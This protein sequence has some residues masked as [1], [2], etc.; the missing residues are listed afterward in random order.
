RSFDRL[1]NL[2]IAQARGRDDEAGGPADQVI[3][4]ASPTTESASRLTAVN[5]AASL[6]R[7]GHQVVLVEAGGS[8]SVDSSPRGVVT[9]GLAEVLAGKATVAQALRRAPYHPGLQVMTMGQ[10]SGTGILQS[11]VLPKVLAA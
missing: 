9:L 6:A 8:T 3:V 11:P 5:L 10:V 1:R 4:V 7:R 2:V